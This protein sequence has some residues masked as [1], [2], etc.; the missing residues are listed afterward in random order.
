LLGRA[1]LGLPEPDEPEENGLVMYEAG[2]TTI[3]REHAVATRIAR[4]ERT[5]HLRQGVMVRVFVCIA[6]LAVPLWAGDLERARQLYARLE[7]EA[8]W[9]ALGAEGSQDPQALL[10]GG[11]IAYQ[12][13][14][15]KDAVARLEQAAQVAPDRADIFLWLGRSLGQRAKAW[16]LSP[17]DYAK[18]CREALERAVALDPTHVDALHDLAS[19]YLKAPPSLGGDAGKAER[20]AVQIAALDAAKGEYLQASMAEARQ[21]FS[22]AEEHL[23]RAVALAPESPKVVFALAELY[24]QR[25]HHLQEARAL[26]QRYLQMPLTPE[27]PPR[28]E[29]ER[30]LV[31]AGG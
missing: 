15:Y 22:R 2:D 28:R 19:Y 1:A 12:R 4:V 30:L 14:Q 10:L 7:Y 26:L 29:A 8:A 9:Q 16:T 23:R 13:G 18:R 6:L 3:T 5:R 27:D 24:I 11:Q 17:F 31:R 21:E 20:L 25:Q